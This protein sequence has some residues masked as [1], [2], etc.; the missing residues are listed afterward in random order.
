[1]IAEADSFGKERVGNNYSTLFGENCISVMDLVRDGKGGKEIVLQLYNDGARC[2]KSKLTITASGRSF[3]PV[4]KHTAAK[5]A[6]VIRLQVHSA[7][8]LYGTGGTSGEK[9]VYVQAYLSDDGTLRTDQR[10]PLPEPER[11]LSL[12]AGKLSGSGSRM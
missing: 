6:K 2:G 3:S 10:S 5:S 1:M 11:N 4:F 12:P 8:H 9:S 7:T